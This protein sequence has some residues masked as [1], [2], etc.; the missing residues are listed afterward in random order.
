M[1]HLEKIDDYRWIIPRSYKAGMLTDA[2][3]F[4]NERLLEAIQKDQSL[5]QAANVAMLPGIVGRAL[6][7]P[8]IHQGY[9]FPIG[10]VAAVDMEHGVVSPGG[11]GFDI[12]CGVRLLGTSL[13]LKDVRPK[14]RDLVHQLF[15]DVPSGTGQSSR[16]NVSETD[17][18]RI[19]EKGPRWAIENDM[20]SEADLDHTEE[21]GCIAGADPRAVSQKARQRGKPQLGTLGS[22]NHFMEV[23]VVDEIFDP[24]TASQYHLERDGIVLLI[25]TG[26]RGLGHQV[27]TDYVSQL[28]EAMH[29]YG[30]KIPD[31][32]L[33]CAPI[34]SPE[35]QRY[36]QAMGAAANFAWTNR[37]CITHAARG[38]FKR[39]FGEDT[40][41]PMIYDVAHNIAKQETHTVDGKE[42]RVLV[43]RKGATRAFPGQAVFIPGS[44]GTASFFLLG[45][46][47]AL[48][49]T[50][51][52]A[53][54]G[55]GRLMSRS[56]AKK[57]FTAKEI[58]K[59]LESRGII[60]Q[61]L[62]R[63]GL[64]EERPEAYK[65]IESV[66]DVVHNAGLASRVARLKPVG[67]IKG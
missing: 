36:L 22:G 42:R 31:R 25:H 27:C 16:L 4:A 21:R 51:G 35:G 19:L 17:L 1:M 65:D 59:D 54:H 13:T 24:K 38:A 9:G 45:Q 26:S 66:V 12:N 37:Q 8:D 63:E 55:A 5:E 49:E 53:C 33:A 15:R 60:V 40:R 32:Q 14:L 28:D 62:T 64:T 50:F 43:H 44:M 46:Q 7:M 10:G 6:A 57:D 41:M 3:I 34:R 67:V 52:S 39:I 30:I 61:S 2:M 48:R 20:G 56:A 11:V 23:Q 58:Q 18:D 47:G 29:R